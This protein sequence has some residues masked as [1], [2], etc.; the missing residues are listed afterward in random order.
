MQFY[1][2]VAWLMQII[3]FLTLGLLVFPSQIIPVMGVGLLISL[4]LM[5]VARPL[6]VFLSL[7]F[8]SLSYRDKLFISWVGL[9]GAVPI[10]FAT[11]PLL[12]GIPQAG[13]I[14]H[15][16]FFITLTSVL[17]QG[18]TLSVVAKWLKL[19]VPERIR[20]IS[21]LEMEL[22][23]NFKSEL[24]EVVIPSDAPVVGKS[25]VQ[26]RFPKS[27]VIVMIS[28]DEKFIRPGGSTVLEA[29]DK[30][31]VMADN[32]TAIHDVYTNLEIVEP[33]I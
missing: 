19:S 33:G 30:L 4:F 32:K 8:F 15:I 22:I 17:L 26:T 27:A 2:G 5:F 13:L 1:D 23:D 24:F 11:Y 28:R 7:S 12:A 29:G 6:S 3:M 14:F 31:L 10:V 16:V 25:I 18:T 20:K 9:R 21:A